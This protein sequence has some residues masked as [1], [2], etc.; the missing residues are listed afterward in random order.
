MNLQI[1]CIFVAF[2]IKMISNV[3]CATFCKV[4]LL[5]ANYAIPYILCSVNRQTQYLV[6]IHIV[7]YRTIH[8]I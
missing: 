6:S 2:D 3:A 4:F 8:N 7:Q 1:S 5:Y